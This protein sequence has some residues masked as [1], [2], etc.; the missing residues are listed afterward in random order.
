MEIWKD[1]VNYEDS[2]QV[3][4]LG[5]V[6]TKDRWVNTGTS[7]R[8]LK[9]QILKGDVNRYGYI[10]YRLWK[11]NKLLNK[12]GHRLVAEHFLINLENKK[13]VNHKNGIKS[14]NRLENLEWSTRSE[15]ILHA[16]ET[17]LE[18]PKTSVI[19]REVFNNIEREILE[20]ESK[21]KVLLKFNCSKR[22]YYYR[23]K[24]GFRY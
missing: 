20:G 14:D 8:F 10:N 3:S 9:S 17:G 1:V 13:E 7:K 2:Y 19:T 18:K 15:N 23:K 5:R 16:F 12:L 11:N 24:F 21:K 22:V 6:R 4:N